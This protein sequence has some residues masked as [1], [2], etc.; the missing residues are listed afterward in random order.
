MF[1]K[2]KG[3]FGQRDMPVAKKKKKMSP[4][5]KS[6]GKKFGLGG[7]TKKKSGSS[8]Q[9]NR[10]SNISIERAAPPKDDFKDPLD[11][12]SEEDQSFE[13]NIGIDFYNDYEP[14]RFGYKKGMIVLEYEIPS[15][16][17]RH[18]HFIKIPVDQ[19]NFQISMSRSGSFK[20]VLRGEVRKLH[21]EIMK[22]HGRYLDHP[23]ITE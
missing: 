22:K 2:N 21:V 16:E 13:E 1:N 14:L 15:K 11:Y 5:K 23:L 17:T 3:F 10:F 19:Q 7:P 8:P 20:E 6:P 9:P 12:D 4:A 18:H